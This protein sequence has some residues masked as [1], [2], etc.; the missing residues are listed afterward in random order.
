MEHI[1]SRSNPLAVH[2][3]KLNA[4]RA[5]RREAREFCCEG[6]KLLQEALHWRAH[7]HTVV[8][9]ESARLPEHLPVHIRQV[10]MPDELVRALAETES[11]QGVLF[12]CEIPS[13]KPPDRLTGRHYLILDGLQDPGNVGSIWRTADA[14]CANGL[15]LIHHCADPYSPKT[16]RATMGAVF[17]FPVW[18]IELDGLKGLLHQAGLPLYAAALR[19]DAADIRAVSLSPAAVI[20]GSEGRGVSDEGLAEC[21]TVLKI[22]MADRCESLNAAAAACVVLWEMYRSY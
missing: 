5:Y 22:P 1:T 20:I 14:F 17:R 9:G 15:F 12:L 8:A 13:L 19:P 2:I 10:I 3:R 21:E 4:S 6:P 16:V 18:E 7:I 11:P